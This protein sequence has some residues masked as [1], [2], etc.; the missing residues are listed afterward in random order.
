MTILSRIFF[1]LCLLGADLTT[2]NAASERDQ[3]V[4]GAAIKFV[5][6]TDPK[7]NAI[8][9]SATSEVLS[10]SKR[11][12]LKIERQEDFVE[13]VVHY[14]SKAE[15]DKM[16]SSHPNWQKGSMVPATYA[17]LG[18]KKEFHVISL[19]AYKKMHP[20]DTDDDYLKLL[21]HELAHLL[22][23]AA[24]GGREDEM[25]PMWFFE[26]LACFAADQ[27]PKST[28]LPIQRI[29][30]ILSDTK[31]GSYAEYAA[32]LRGLTQK[33]S[34]ADLTKRASSKDFSAWVRRVLAEAEKRND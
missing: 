31:R 27:Y 1:C 14:E 17:G 7:F 28:S 18:M 11:H 26:G 3:K 24:I 23:I 10:F 2:V 34:I 33:E 5:G 20:S 32:M 29:D 6:A 30:E 13:T 22:H 19:R 12:R 16:I 21:V 4:Q 15:F 9:Q 8:V 25:G